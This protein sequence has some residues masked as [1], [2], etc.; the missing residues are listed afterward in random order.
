MP[1]EIRRFLIDFW[2]RRWPVLFLAFVLQLAASIFILLPKSSQPLANLVH[3]RFFFLFGITLWAIMAEVMAN[4]MRALVALPFTA[5]SVFRG[6]W[7]L[8]F[9]LPAM[10]TTAT[11]LIALVVALLLG[12]LGVSNET[13]IIWII[14]QWGSLALGWCCLCL[15]PANADV[16]RLRRA[17]AFIASSL[18]GVQSSFFLCFIP[19]SFPWG[20]VV[21]VVSVFTILGAL[22]GG[23]LTG[24]FIFERLG[25][26][27][28]GS[29]TVPRKPVGSE[30]KPGL[31]GWWTLLPINLPVFSFFISLYIMIQGTLIWFTSDSLA[32]HEYP[33]SVLSPVYIVWGQMMMSVPFFSCRQFSDGIRVFRQ[34]PLTGLKLA[35]IPLFYAW[36]PSLIFIAGMTCVT[37]GFP[38]MSMT[39]WTV[40]ALFS[41]TLVSFVPGIAI[42]LGSRSKGVWASGVLMASMMGLSLIPR[43]VHLSLWCL[44]AVPVLIFIAVTW[45]RWEIRC[46]RHAYRNRPL[47]SG[48]LIT[49]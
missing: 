27:S 24:Q 33:S 17:S 6:F 32:R 16:A 46:G 8:T 40:I 41:L 28:S 2:H 48:Q 36:I 5:E 35:A 20:I 22:A 43:F 34:L 31:R 29:E 14:G 19:M 42:R 1:P 12:P 49:N 26:P 15:I 25:R 9:G 47:A 37:V 4:P 10:A 30:S 38:G 3:D 23:A 7:W 13:V 45:T 44:S 21:L 11:S 18:W 39:D